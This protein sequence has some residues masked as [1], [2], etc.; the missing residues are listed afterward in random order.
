MNREDVLRMAREAGLTDPDLGDWMTDYGHSEVAIKKFAAAI[1]SATKEEDAEIA[2]REYKI[3][4]D[5]MAAHYR[6]SDTQFRPRDFGFDIG[7]LDTSISIRDAI[8]ASK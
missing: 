5:T 2:G 3:Y 4:Q 7:V 1:R 6:L 8:R